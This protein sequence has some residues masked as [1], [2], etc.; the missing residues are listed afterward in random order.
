MCGKIKKMDLELNGS[1]D[2][3]RIVRRKSYLRLVI[4]H[5]RIKNESIEFWLPEF[6]NQS[7]YTLYKS[8]PNWTAE[9]IIKWK[10]NHIHFGSRAAPRTS[11]MPMNKLQKI[12][13]R[14]PKCVITSYR[15][16]VGYEVQYCERLNIQKK[17]I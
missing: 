11:W 3:R 10:P 13:S 12:K 6:M 5:P 8:R 16:G 7:D 14:L 4:V 2:L 1:R 15:G 9:E 17:A